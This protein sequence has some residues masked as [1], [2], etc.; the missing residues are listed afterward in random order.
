MRLQLLPAM[1]QALRS[2]R[3]SDA[4]AL[5]AALMG[6]A[7]YPEV[8]DR[9]RRMTDPFPRVQP[10]ELA[11]LDVGTFGRAY[12]DFMH[13]HQLKWIRLSAEVE[14]VLI[15]EDRLAI[16]YLLLHD[17]FHVLLGF[18]VSPA[19]ELGVWTFVGAQRYSRSFER[20]ATVAG[21]FYA[22]THPL[23]VGPLRRARHRGLALAARARCLIAE[24]MEQW[25]EEP[26]E[27][28]RSRL[29]IEGPPGP[30]RPLHLRR[31]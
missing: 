17:A 8:A 4:A 5:K 6:T 24:P 26:L 25:W 10:S 12:A 28:L 30:D 16:R 2:G 18:D 27:P 14:S 29:G 21:V 11:A 15:P 7:A 31:N 20:A 19:G 1:I 23:T 22:I 3:L 13:T 9:L